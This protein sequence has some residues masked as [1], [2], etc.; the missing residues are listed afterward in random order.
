MGDLKALAKGDPHHATVCE[1]VELLG[2]ATADFRDG[3]P[4]TA[5]A[6]SLLGAA[7]LIFAG[8]SF[9]ALM[10]EG[11]FSAEELHQLDGCALKNFREGVRSGA[12]AVVR[13]RGK[14]TTQ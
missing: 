12:K 5:E 7:G 11:H 1:L 4:D 14:G 6:L 2:E 9:G 10:A 13:H 8:C 3:W